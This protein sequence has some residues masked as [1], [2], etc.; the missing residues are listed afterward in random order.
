LIGGLAGL[1][2]CSDGTQ[3]L[4]APSRSAAGALNTQV[5]AAVD[6]AGDGG[7]E[8][9]VL[10]GTHHATYVYAI[11]GNEV[12]NP[13]GD[14]H[15]ATAADIARLRKWGGADK[16]VE[17]LKKIFKPEWDRLGLMDVD[18]ASVGEVQRRALPP[19]A[20]SSVER[21]SN[22]ESSGA[23]ANLIV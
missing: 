23:H 18:E 1:F 10:H 15:T 6:A 12:T 4:V 20:Q 8:I 2:A 3:D 9:V 17:S 7:P 13:H 14:T 5:Y 16:R 21:P 19:G 11:R 22:R